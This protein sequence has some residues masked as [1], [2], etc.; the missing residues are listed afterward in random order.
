MTSFLPCITFLL[1]QGRYDS[2]V[3]PPDHPEG[4]A[5]LWLRAVAHDREAS[6]IT[7]SFSSFLTYIPSFQVQGAAALEEIKKVL[8]QI[9]DVEKA[10]YTIDDEPEDD[11][12]EDDAD[13]EAD[14]GADDEDYEGSGAR[15]PNAAHLIA[16]SQWRGLFTDDVSWRIGGCYSFL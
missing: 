6:V 14:D 11:V 5:S 8:S 16:I 9:Y 15:G 2:L 13:D 1:F 7:F 12:P 3:C 10:G 4:S